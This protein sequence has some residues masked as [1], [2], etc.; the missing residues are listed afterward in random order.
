ML[1]YPLEGIDCPIYEYL[2][3]SIRDDIISGKLSPSE[4]LPSKRSLARNNGVSTITIQNAYDQLIAE[5]YVT[6][7]EKKGYFV[8]ERPSGKRIVK[9]ARAIP[10]L[11]EKEEEYRI[12]L[13]NNSTDPE[14][15]PFSIWSRLTREILSTSKDRLMKPSPSCGVHELRN[16]ISCYLSSFRAM[17][18]APEQIVIGAGTEY[19]YSLLIQLLGRDKHY[20]IENPGYSKLASIYRMNNARFSYVGIDDEGLSAES[21]EESGAEIAHISPN[22]HFPTGIT[23]PLRR[24]YEILA[25]AS[26]ESGRYIIEDDYDS[27][28]RIAR[29]PIPTLESI[30]GEGKVIYMNT[31]SKSLSSTIRISYM[32]L[33]PELALRFGKMLSFYSCTVPNFEQ[34]TLARFIS[35]G[36]FEKHINRMRLYYIRQRRMMLDRISQ[37][38]IRDHASVIENDS[39][40]HFMLRLDTGME[41]SAITEALKGKGIHISAL[42][43]YTAAQPGRKGC[44]IINYSNLRADDLSEALEELAGIIQ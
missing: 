12:D 40:L 20:A 22:H 42:S 4:K 8:A 23:M 35:E 19:L 27:E 44:F 25:W 37:S 6:A 18:V 17:A 15:F 16:A 11:E 33:P 13:S 24:R 3:K 36:Y 5:G 2:Y 7:I 26:R 38:P 9:E 10:M 34:Y 29:T 14:C 30:D 28:F 32:V 43:E 39:G 41:D 1:T 21:L 31:F